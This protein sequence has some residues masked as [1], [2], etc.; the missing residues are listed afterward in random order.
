MTV[1]RG[2]AGLSDVEWGGA[3]PPFKLGLTISTCVR[4]ASAVSREI[5]RHREGNPTG[6]IGP[7]TAQQ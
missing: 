2:G 5:R 3:G 1:G 6:L 4:R 7:L